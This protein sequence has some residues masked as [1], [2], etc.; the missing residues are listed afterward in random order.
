MSS[1]EVSSFQDKSAGGLGFMK[2][3]NTEIWPLAIESVDFSAAPTDRHSSWLV[4]EVLKGWRL[5]RGRRVEW[6]DEGLWVNC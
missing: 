2:T 4:T 5:Q 3:G 6:M 1:A